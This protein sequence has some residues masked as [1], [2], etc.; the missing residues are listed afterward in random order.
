MVKKPTTFSDAM[1]LSYGDQHI[2]N[3]QFVDKIQKAILVDKVKDFDEFIKDDLKYELYMKNFDTLPDVEIPRP[4]KTK[5]SFIATIPDKL[6]FGEDDIKIKIETDATSYDGDVVDD[7]VA[8]YNRALDTITPLKVGDT[9]IIFTAE[10]DGEEKTFEYPIHVV[11]EVAPPAPPPALTLTHN[12]PAIFTYAKDTNPIKLNI[13][14]NG[15]GILVEVD[16]NKAHFDQANSTLEI[17]DLTFIPESDHN[18]PVKITAFRG[19]ETKIVNQTIQWKSYIGG[20]GEVAIALVEYFERLNKELLLPEAS[21]AMI[22]GDPIL[23]YMKSDWI[24][25]GNGATDPSNG[26]TYGITESS[27]SDFASNLLTKRTWASFYCQ[28]FNDS[29]KEEAGIDIE[30]NK[31][32]MLKRE[33][34]PFVSMSGSNR[35]YNTA[36]FLKYFLFNMTYPQLKKYANAQNTS[37]AT[38][39]EKVYAIN[40]EMIVFF[41]SFNFKP[42]MIAGTDY[43]A[44][45]HDGNGSAYLY[46]FG[47]LSQMQKRDDVLS[48]MNELVTEENGRRNPFKYYKSTKEIDF[49]CCKSIENYYLKGGTLL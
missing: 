27:I 12:I 4:E 21:S 11:D 19:D 35:T 10:K 30:I 42:Q 31:K 9:R 1:P 3:N 7:S 2:I 44:F 48:A 38:D 49:L 17:Y 47:L 43:S 29:H 39:T 40:V 36:E 8:F 37:K 26:K 24:T 18:I 32:L 41:E 16:E 5:F 20:D 23:D 46:Y 6:E 45:T 13:Q 25:F 22:Y 14:T 28:Y 34:A 33:N 15:S